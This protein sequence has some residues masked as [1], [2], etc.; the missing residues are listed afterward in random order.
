MYVWSKLSSTRWNDAWEERFAGHPDLSLVL[1]SVPS[2]DT[3]RVEVYSAKKAPLLAVQK[4]FGGRLRELK[5][6]NWAAITTP[7]MPPLKVRDR[8]VVC[9]ARTPA[10]ITR[11]A[12]AHPGR[13]IIAIPAD[14]AFGTGH[15]ATTATMLRLLVDAAKPLAGQR[16]SFADLG[17]GTGILAIAAAKLGA[18]KVW[19]CDFDPK[20]VKVAREN[21]ARNAVADVRMAVTDILEWQPKQAYDIVAANIFHDVLEAAFPQIIDSVKPG[22]VLMVSGIL[23]SQAEGCLAVA[24]RLGIEWQHVVTRG[25]KWVSALGRRPAL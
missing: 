1:T 18:A 14:M 11:A 16:W 15:H 2:S 4:Q 17:S 8:L 10:E 13:E 20:A 3:V 5:N 23:K 7:P 21:L 19:G 25:G 24:A 12:K 6:R 22:G 9:T